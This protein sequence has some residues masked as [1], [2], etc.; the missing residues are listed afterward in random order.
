VSV[1]DW[2]K[3]DGFTDDVIAVGVLAWFTVCVSTA[4]VL[5]A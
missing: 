3:V 4:E 5:V 2:P 1:T